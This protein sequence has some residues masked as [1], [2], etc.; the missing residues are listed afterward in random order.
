[1]KLGVSIENNYSYINYTQRVE[2]VAGN[3]KY[4]FY[5]IQTVEEFEE[6]EN[7]EF[8]YNGIIFNSTTEVKLTEEGKQNIKGKQWVLRFY[9]SDYADYVETTVPPLVSATPINTKIVD[10]TLVSNVTILRLKFETNDIVYNLGVIDNK[11]TGDGN[12]DNYT[13]TTLELSDTFKII[14][15]VL[16]LILLVV[17]LGPFLPTI[18]SVVVWIF[19][20]AFKLVIWLISLPIK[21][22]KWLFDS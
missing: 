13:K 12:P 21:L 2:E 15:A 10:K 16:F 17:V 4:E 6:T 8:V 11:Q 20:L 22:F 14:L 7:Y 19:K 5:R 18:I 3:Y 1:M 9:E